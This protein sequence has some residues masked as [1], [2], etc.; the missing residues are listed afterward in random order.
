[1]W[2]EIYHGI[3]RR[4]KAWRVATTVSKRTQITIE[5]SRVLIIRRTRSSRAR[6][7]ECAREVE[8]V[9]LEEAS[10]LTGM[11]QPLLRHNVE[12]RK[13]HFSESSGGALLI[14]LDS[15]MKSMQSENELTN[16]E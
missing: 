9:G 15:L 6:C 2:S 4:A 10:V 16:G 11:T 12:T 1:M 13:W 7:R 8:V 3:V 5:T 14:C